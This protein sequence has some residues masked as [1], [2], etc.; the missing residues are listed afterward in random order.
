MTCFDYL[1]GG[2]RVLLCAI[3]MTFLLGHLGSVSAQTSLSLSDVVADALQNSVD[4][5]RLDRD[6]ALRLADA[7]E[8]ETRPNPEVEALARYSDKGE[9]VGLELEVSQPLRFSDFILRPLYAAAIRQT[10]TIEQE[11]GL[12]D[13]VNRVTELYLAHWAA[14]SREAMAR[15]AAENATEINNQID[16]IRRE[17]TLPTAQ[18]NVF[19]P[20]A[21]RRREEATLYAAERAVLEARLA[22]ETGG[23]GGALISAAAAPS[24]LPPL[25]QLLAFAADREFGA[26]MARAR[27]TVNEARLRVAEKDRLPMITPR[28]NYDIDPGGADRVWGI[29]VAVEVPFWDRNGAEVARAQAALRESR[30]HLAQLK[31][32]A[33][34]ALVIGLYRQ[35]ALLDSRAEAYNTRI[36]PA[37]R[38]TYQDIRQIYDQGQTDLLDLWQVQAS[39]LDAEEDAI[40]TVIDALTARVALERAIGGK[41]EQVN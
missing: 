22:F 29:G 11:A 21:L 39:L 14:Q 40:T 33:R 18:F 28:L 1:R 23:D 35:V 5:V 17:Q 2:L 13:L 12:F 26:R 9:G 31:G 34:E 41:I 4:V 3:G 30:M 7:I 19:V 10:A 32:G 38:K 37:Y 15:K 16:F 25:E 27:I 20:E 36:V 8:V 6:L 24:P